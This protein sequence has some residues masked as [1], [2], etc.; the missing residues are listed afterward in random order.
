MTACFGLSIWKDKID[1]HEAV[2]G[3]SLGAKNRRYGTVV[4]KDFVRNHSGKIE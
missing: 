1:K 4:F 2:N 3:V